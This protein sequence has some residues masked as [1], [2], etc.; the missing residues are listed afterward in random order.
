MTNPRVLLE[1]VALVRR[2][3]A[4]S[5]HPQVAR[6]GTLGEITYLV[7]EHVTQVELQLLDALIASESSQDRR[8]FARRRLQ[9]HRDALT[10]Y[11]GKHLLKTGMQCESR[12][13]EIY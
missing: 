13:Y 12:Q 4:A 6:V 7:D 2:L 10:P 11:L 3:L 1:H 8:A 5:E 9:Q